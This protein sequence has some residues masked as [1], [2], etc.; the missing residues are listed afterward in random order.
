[1]GSP[2]GGR[3]AERAI[4]C[5]RAR[6]WIA[7]IAI[8]LLA[9]CGGSERVEVRLERV[10]PA[11]DP[12]C[13][14]PDDARTLV[15][16]ALGEFPATEATARSVEV[17]DGVDISIDGFPPA[18]NSLELEV[19]GD[20]GAVRAVGRTQEFALAD[21]DGDAVITAFMAPPGGFCPTGPPAIARDAPLAA[22]AGRA[23]LIAGGTGAGGDPV[24]QVELYDPATGQ[25]SGLGA[26]LYGNDIDTGLAGASMT[27]LPGGRV[28]VA[29]GGATAF[30]VYDPEASGFGPPQFLRE[31][32]AH[33]AAVALDGDRLLLAG[34]CARV[35]RAG[36]TEGT[37]LSTS[38]ILTVSTGELVGG[39]GLTRL[40][41]GGSALREADGRVL[42]VGGVGDD[43]APLTEAER[44]DPVGGRAAELVADTGAEAALLA[45]G[46]ALTGFA[47]SGS[48]PSPIA[49][50]VPPGA[51][52]ATPLG[53]AI[54]PRA[55][56]A[57]VP[58]ENG[59]VLVLGG[60]VDDGG[61]EPAAALYAPA[62]GTVEPLAAAPG[63]GGLSGH[64]AVRLEDGSVLVV[65]GRD[66]AG[67]PLGD[68]W[69]FRPDLT[70]P[71]TA[72]LSATFA[73][74]ESAAPMVPR[75]P[76]RARAVAADGETP[77]HYRIEASDDRLPS[78]WAVLAGPRF[79]S[80]S[81]DASI[82]AEQG[83]AA[84]LLWFRD[85]ATT[86]VLELTPGDEPRLISLEQGQERPLGTCTGQPIGDGDLAP[87]AGAGHALAVD[88]VSGQ[89]VASLDG[90]IVLRCAVEPPAP[91]LV[92]VAP[93]G[94]AGAVLRLDLLSASR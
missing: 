26:P 84:V 8:G 63:D 52:R 69:I 89:L 59:K 32:R 29:G 66:A 45:A 33:H 34:G 4:P 60:D 58:L 46:G 50:V 1:M 74:P 82:A 64:A 47:P 11:A 78:E 57:L 5:A 24:D 77:A 22:R 2:G 21:L 31:A 70:G 48:A 62:G 15:V 92:G 61:G 25:F 39:P 44:I 37:A 41:I 36:C 16:T 6:A 38:T 3:G 27:A 30:Q 7:C 79:T 23:V 53:D 17:A 81:L 42:L 83:G 55:G 43:G 68:A 56:P 85:E 93:L 72:G 94:G 73:T 49:A 87:P 88:A 9:A 13:G 18:T 75:D 86:A 35:D 19:R 40:R 54:A 28:V 65:G 51:L 80:L 10:A 91:G 71:W 90:R 20:G 67:E 76:A 14:A 12:D